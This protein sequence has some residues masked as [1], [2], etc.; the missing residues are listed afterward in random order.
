MYRFGEHEIDIPGR[1]VRRGGSVVHL[2]PQAFD[3]LAVLLEH[4]ARVV[5]K[6]ERLDSVWGHRHVSE[7]ALTT[8]I[9]EIRRAVG[10]DGRRQSVIKNVP[11][12]GYRFVAE[13]DADE[14]RTSPAPPP[15]GHVP[16]DLVGRD[17]LLL[18]VV[19]SLGRGRVVTLLGPG[20][21]GK[22]TLAGAVL[23]HCHDH[24]DDQV[25]MVDLTTV[26]DGSDVMPVMARALD[27]LLEAGNED[28]ACVAM[29]TQPAIVLVD[30]CE[31][32]VDA[33]C[34]VLE[35][36]FASP[37]AVVRVLATSQVRL[38]LPAETVVAVDPLAADDAV[39]LFVQRARA[40]RPSFDG[41]AMHERVVGLVE[42]LDRLPLALEMAAARLGSMTLDDLEA[43]VLSPT[44]MVQVTHR[45][46]TRRHRTLTSVV[47]W[48]TALLDDEQRE[49]LTECSV[50]AGSFGAR[51]ATA[52]LSAG[53]AAPAQVAALVER[54]LLSADL[55]GRTARY[56]M[57]E[58][59]K[60]VTA[61]WLQ[62][63]PS[64]TDVHRRHARWVSGELEGIDRRLR[65]DEEV[66]AR[67]RLD[68][69]VADVRRAYLWVATDAPTEAAR[70]S[71]LLH[72]AAYSTFWR[73]PAV[74]SR[75]LLT[76]HPDLS[77]AD[78]AG[79]HVVVAADAANRG[80]LDDAR[81]HL[82]PLLELDDP[83]IVGSALEV[84]TD[85]EIYSG[86]LDEARRS[87]E[88]LRQLGVELGDRHLVAWADVNFSLAS[89]FA[90]EP[91]VALD[92]LDRAVPAGLAPS[93]LAW[94][95]YSR[96]EALAVL[97]RDD[98]AA[99]FERAIDIS[100]SAGNPFV[101]SVSQQSLAGCHAR[102]GRVAEALDAYR[103]CLLD[104]LRHGNMVHSVTTVRNLVE[105]L[106][107]AGAPRG[108]V[109]LLGA[110]GR[111]ELRRNYGAEA[112]RQRTVAADLEQLLG[113][114]E[115]DDC[116]A[117][118]AHLVID[119]AM[120]RAVELIDELRPQR[121]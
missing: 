81:S 58:T 68:D 56:R 1:E 14:S 63:H 38:G 88:R 89:T 18:T 121:G 75:A 50:F 44:H 48:S 90:D 86:Q 55:E 111:P 57:L 103:E 51:D 94:L 13:L 104:S 21:V 107:A 74:W 72:H 10:D 76:D 84:M 80:D 45:T 52:V 116:L 115:Y 46:P 35:R 54:S 16:S 19:G 9:K 28:R 40:V 20:G 22:S 60:S 82:L 83:T 53:A 113:S 98:A 23:R 93:D 64:T 31:H 8:R 117:T 26:R 118:G 92:R 43:A 42:Q 70:W 61:A 6:H 119:A 12:R 106:A 85:V 114:A 78:L 30:N 69:V 33:V 96:G 59:V 7:A 97:D 71:A 49:A 29:A 67:Q 95:E 4:R 17:E 2:E 120:R 108:A 25:V 3:L 109:E 77:A 100:R 15:A 110:V 11:G 36:M 102:A 73:E 101:V 27:A 62:R 66:T 91:Q 47:E 5:P 112:E 79:A 87:A 34:D 37:G 24:G 65:T 39:D 105:L 99:A 41:T 32:V